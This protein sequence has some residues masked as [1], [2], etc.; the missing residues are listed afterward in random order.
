MR[1]VSVWRTFA[2][3]LL[4]YRLDAAAFG[5]W[6]EWSHSDSRISAGYALLAAPAEDASDITDAVQRHV[7]HERE[8]ET[9]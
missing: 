6:C 3:M 4:E 5:T 8:Q 7:P 9:V 1:R 2:G